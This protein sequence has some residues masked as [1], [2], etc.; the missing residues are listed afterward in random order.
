MTEKTRQD[1]LSGIWRRKSLPAIS[2]IMRILNQ[3]EG[4]VS[5]RQVYYQLVSFGAI[6]PT[7]AGYDK[8]QRLLVKLRREG[9]IPS[10]KICDRTRQKHQL[11]SWN[12]LS[13]LLEDMQ[14]LYRRDFWKD[15]PIIVYIGLEKAGLE[16]VVADVCNKFGVGLFVCRGY[17]SYALLYDWA[18]EIRT[19]NAEGK[20]VRI[21]Y[22]GDFDATGLDIDRAIET[23]LREFGARFDFQRIGLM[24]EDLDSFHLLPLSVKHSDKRARRFLETYGDRAAEL[25]ALPPNELCR[26]I[27]GAISGSIDGVRWGEVKAIEN[28]E[29]ETLRQVISSLGEVA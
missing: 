1:S 28:A 16:G 7:N 10:W 4:K 14:G 3:A 26:R 9:V 13:D 8:A 5:T 15:Q 27:E 12:G 6:Q 11:I 24:P 17:A 25:D 29:R 20:E 2:A 21:F 18:E 19:W 23:T 22:A